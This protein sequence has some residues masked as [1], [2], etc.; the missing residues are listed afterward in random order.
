M[1][2]KALLNP[3]GLRKH[4]TVFTVNKMSLISF[5]CFEAGGERCMNCFFDVMT[6]RLLIS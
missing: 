2:W 6:Q 4:F 5:K 3:E 1:K